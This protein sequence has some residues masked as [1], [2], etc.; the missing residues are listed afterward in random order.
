M[1]DDS[2]HRVVEA[3]RGSDVVRER[4]D[5]RGVAGRLLFGEVESVREAREHVDPAARPYANLP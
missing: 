1:Q 2:P 5:A 4:C 3:E